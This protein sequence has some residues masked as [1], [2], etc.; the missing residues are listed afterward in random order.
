MGGGR[1]PWDVGRRDRRTRPPVLDVEAFADRVAEVLGP[2]LRDLGEVPTTLAV[3][4]GP[5]MA[6]LVRACQAVRGGSPHI[7]PIVEVVKPW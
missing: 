1:L 6:H 7:E 2:F 5:A 4:L 3:A